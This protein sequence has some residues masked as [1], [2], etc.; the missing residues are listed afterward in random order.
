MLWSGREMEGL[1]LGLVGSC[2]VGLGWGFLG[3]WNE[4]GAVGTCLWVLKGT[5][6]SLLDAVPQAP[7]PVHRPGFLTACA[8][9][10]WYHLYKA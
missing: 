9:C 10:S 7:I 2:G 5:H 6:I 8:N 1:R 3:I 4:M